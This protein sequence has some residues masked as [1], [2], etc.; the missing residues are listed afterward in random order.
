MK[1]VY[2]QHLYQIEIV[3]QFKEFKYRVMNHHFYDTILQYYLN[4]LLLLSQNLD[5]NRSDILRVQKLNKLS[6]STLNL[7]IH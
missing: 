6:F 1:K 5:D 4:N 2:T 7:L 3:F